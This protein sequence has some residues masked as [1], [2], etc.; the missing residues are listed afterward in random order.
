MPRPILDRRQ[1]EK[2]K[3]ALLEAL[4]AERQKELEKCTFA[5]KITPFVPLYTAR[6]AKEPVVE[7]MQKMVDEQRDRIQQVRTAIYIHVVFLGGK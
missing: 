6:H 1:I 4:E 5:P 3:R 7:R 2:K